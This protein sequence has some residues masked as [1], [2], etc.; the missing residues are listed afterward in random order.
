MEADMLKRTTGNRTQRQGI[1]YGACLA[2]TMLICASLAHADEKRLPQ[3]RGIKVARPG[4]PTTVVGYSRRVALAIGINQ[5]K[6]YPHLEYAAPDAESIAGVFK[7]YGFDEVILITDKDAHRRRI[8]N[9]LLRLKVSARADDLFVFYFAGHGQ[10]VSSPDRGEM[11]YLIPTDCMRGSETDQAISMGIIK[12]IADT[13]PNRHLLFLVDACYSGYGLA[14]SVAT[15]TPT[16]L[17]ADE[18]IRTMLPLRSVQVL[19]AGGKDDQ[20]HESM[21]HGIF[22]RYLLDSLTSATTNFAPG[23]I[24]VLQLSSRVKQEVVRA[25]KGAQNPHF[26]YLYGNGDVILTVTDG[27]SKHNPERRPSGENVTRE[28]LMVDFVRVGQLWKTGQ[29]REAELLMSRINRDSEGLNGIDAEAR[30]QFLETIARLSSAMDKHDM[31]LYYLKELRLSNTNEETTCFALTGMGIACREKGDFKE[32][33]THYQECLS[34]AIKCYG[35]TNELVAETYKRIGE[36]YALQRRYQEALA[37]FQRCE[38]IG[39]TVGVSNS[40]GMAGVYDDYGTVYLH[41]EQWEKS[42]QYYEQSLAMKLKLLP[43]TDPMLALSYSNLG[44]LRVSQRR[45]TDALDMHRKALAIR[46]ESFGPDHGEVASSYVNISVALLEVGQYAQAL[47][48]Q[49]RAL[50]LYVKL[51]DS[52]H[53][54]V[55]TSYQNMGAIMLSRGETAKAVLYLQNALKASENSPE[56]DSLVSA[57]AHYQLGLAYVRL[58]DRAKAVS[59]LRKATSQ[60]TLVLGRDN[61]LTQHARS[62]LSRLEVQ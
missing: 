60:L 7:T 46:L 18:Y 14:R 43:P 59:H 30:R 19:T 32:A 29:V 10:T 36:V 21:G 2:A 8:I 1:R 38:E 17:A 23:C 56:P 61:P 40:L 42:A 9:E 39:L 5:Y 25:T 47:E 3:I 31:A 49:Q 22:T 53:P 51:Y 62:E 52:D 35:T 6:D 54:S 48:Y 27:P 12:D 34:T 28:Q 26:G 44:N 33:L 20:A 50:T 13:M 41:L 55:A 37:S 58:S 57:K 15:T 24:S 11:G 16:S 45:F 4:P